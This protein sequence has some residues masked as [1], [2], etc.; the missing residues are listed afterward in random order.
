MADGGVHK[1]FQRFIKPAH[2]QRIESGM[3]SLGIPDHNYCVNGSEGWIEN[4]WTDSWKV[5]VR[6]D[7]VGWA[8]RRERNGGKVL[9]A[10]RQT[11]KDRGG[12]KRDSLWLL[13]TGAFRLL[14]DGMRLDLLPSSLV[15]VRSEGGPA[16]W[17]WAEVRKYL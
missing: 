10:V 13:N 5:K 11:G 9:M 17:D 1:E 4:K 15:L 14:H 7:Q 8:E 2:W 12:P 3:T 16:S 6:G